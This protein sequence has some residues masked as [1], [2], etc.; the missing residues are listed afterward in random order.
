MGSTNGPQQTALQVLGSL[1]GAAAVIA[2]YFYLTGILVTIA[3]LWHAG[4]SVRDTLPLLSLEQLLGRGIAAGLVPTVVVVISA[5]AGVGIYWGAEKRFQDR[6]PEKLPD[7]A[8]DLPQE[9]RQRWLQAARDANTRTDWEGLRKLLAEAQPHVGGD[10][11][12][13]I[14]SLRLRAW[15]ANAPG[16]V[17]VLA[18]FVAL[19]F[20]PPVLAVAAV[21][22]AILWGV[23]GARPLW[24]L[25][26]IG[27][28][29]VVLA[30]FV[31]P[32]VHPRSLP[33]ATIATDK[34][35]VVEGTFLFIRE[36]RW[37]VEGASDR[38]RVVEPDDVRWA[39]IEHGPPREVLLS[40]ILNELFKS[41]ERDGDADG[42]PAV[43]DNCPTTPNPHQQDADGDGAADAC[44]R[45]DDDDRLSDAAER[46][47]N[48]SSADLDSDDDGLTDAREDRKRD[49]RRRQ[50][51]THP[52]RYDTDHDRLPD[53]LELGLRHGV[54]DP[55]GLVAGSGQ[56]F[57]RDRDPQTT[58][59]PLR[60]DTD[61]GGVPDGDEDRNRNGRLDP[62]ETDPND[63][64]KQRH[65]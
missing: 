1:T 29:V 23:V 61:H 59:S 51:E 32:W 18:L 9:D 49:G 19:F 48:T 20:L 15:V 24:Q 62:G 60:R 21:V 36:G 5:V 27:Y 38:V 56:R 43:P 42:V 35:G 63:P 12:K 55:P 11:K 54:A 4:I 26:A 6:V 31:T 57:R 47:L 30:V 10:A 58:T 13:E 46:R 53:G 44:D 17:L 45:D 52:A 34:T 65:P 16:I 25:L 2:G 37:F 41:D 14:A 3:E 7:I 33:T 22:T 28:A 39:R 50:R 64:G 40:I 8:S